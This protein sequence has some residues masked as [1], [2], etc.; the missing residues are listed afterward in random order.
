[1]ILF[2][3][4]SIDFSGVKP[5]SGRVG[6][7]EKSTLSMP[8]CVAEVGVTN[9]L[10]NPVETYT[11][12]VQMELVIWLS[13]ATITHPVP[14]AHSHVHSYT[15]RKKLCLEENNSSANSLRHLEEQG[16]CGC[17]ENFPQAKNY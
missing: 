4:S 6:W 13:Q 1:M 8:N 17:Q 16:N 11:I 5:I 15:W 10:Y 12:I 9:V 7:D 14:Y 3:S 2:Y